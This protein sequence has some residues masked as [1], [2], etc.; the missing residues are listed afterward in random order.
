MALSLEFAQGTADDSKKLIGKLFTP[1]DLLSAYRTARL[2]L[3]TSDIVLQVSEQ[4]PSGFEARTRA[5]YIAQ[6]KALNSGR[7]LPI[8]LR[9]IVEQSAHAVA[10]LPPEADAWWLILVRG[11]QA[12]PVMCVIYAIQYT[13]EEVAVS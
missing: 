1:T 2:Q 13:T 10:T 7:P 11:L 6:A 5:Q 12:V 4:D 9:G 3:Q 8:L